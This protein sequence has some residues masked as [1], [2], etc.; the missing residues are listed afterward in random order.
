M[1]HEN[2]EKLYSGEAQRLDFFKTDA[3]SINFGNHCFSLRKPLKFIGNMKKPSVN[4]K[5]AHNPFWSKQN[6]RI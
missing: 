6:L 1:A 2:R 3:S 5:Y 4:I